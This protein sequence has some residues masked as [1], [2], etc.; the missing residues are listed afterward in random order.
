MQLFISTPET[1]DTAPRLK[2]LK[3]WLDASNQTC[4]LPRPLPSPIQSLTALLSSPFICSIMPRVKTSHEGAYASSLSK[5]THRPK[6]SHLRTPPDRGLIEMRYQWRPSVELR[7]RALAEDQPL[8]ETW[9]EER[10]SR[11]TLSEITFIG[12]RCNL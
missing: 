6:V 3:S 10:G 12:V 5:P 1:L 2:A 9:W 11:P 8:L 4:P 7:G